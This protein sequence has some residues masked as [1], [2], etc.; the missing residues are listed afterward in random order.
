MTPL[1]HDVRT[2]LDGGQQYLQQ[3]SGDPAWAKQASLQSLDDLRQQQAW[4][5]SYF[6]VFFLCAVL[7]LA[8]V[9]LV[10]FMRRSVAE[11]GERISSE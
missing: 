8:L 10:F 5:L 2:Y 1:N 4:S 3:F 7:S 11:K 6:D 9:A